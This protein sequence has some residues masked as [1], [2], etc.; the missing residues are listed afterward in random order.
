MT[1]FRTQPARLLNPRSRRLV[2]ERL[3]ATGFPIVVTIC[4]KTRTHLYR[5]K[6][7]LR[8]LRGERRTDQRVNRRRMA[9]T[10][11]SLSRRRFARN[12]LGL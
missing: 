5:Q 1:F 6:R 11:P 7:G 2:V 10:V 9:R 4:I 8:R 3:V 12:K